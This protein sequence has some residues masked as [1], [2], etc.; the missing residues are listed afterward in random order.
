MITPSVGQ[1]LSAVPGR[2]RFL[3]AGSASP[4]RA[5]SEVPER[6]LAFVGEPPE[7]PELPPDVEAEQILNSFGPVSEEAFSAHKSSDNSGSGMISENHGI[8]CSA[9][10]DTP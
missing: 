4:Y 5:L 7:L 2:N 8:T 3:A 1:A 6:L 9:S 10:Y